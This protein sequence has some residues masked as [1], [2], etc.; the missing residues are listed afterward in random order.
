MQHM[1]GLADDASI[2]IVDD[3][4]FNREGM[5]L[6]LTQR[7]FHVAEAGDETTALA[8]AQ[9]Q[10]FDVAI[11]D[12]AIPQWPHQ[13]AHPAHSTGI[14]LARR[15]KQHDPRIGIV[16]FSA[17]E[18]R[19]QEVLKLMEEVGTSGLAYVLKGC[20]PDYLVRMIHLVCRGQTFLDPEIVNAREAVQNLMKDWSP[21]ERQLVEGVLQKLAKLT[22]RERQVVRLLAN[23]LTPEAIAQQL[24]ISVK[25]V[26]NHVTRIYQKLSLS[27][28]PSHLRRVNLL[29]KAWLIYA[30]TLRDVPASDETCD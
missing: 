15:L 7:G 19:G 20:A 10:R 30:Y 22:S 14:R 18:D 17:Y 3:D 21:E 13:R 29:T 28:A 1:G 12:I 25:T 27:D 8:L 26:E 2:L 5:R 6:Y 11:L 9:Q 4:A 24:D 16:L 23:S